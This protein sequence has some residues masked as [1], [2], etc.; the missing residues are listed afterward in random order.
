MKNLRKAVTAVMLTVSLVGSFGVAYADADISVRMDAVIS[1]GSDY[2]SFG[3]VKPMQIDNR[4]LIPARD[5]AEAAGM[6]VTWDQTTQTA[7]L[8]LTADAYSDKPIERYAAQLISQIEGFGLDLRPTSITAA[9][10]LYDST[11]VIRY[12]FTDSEGD[13]VPM[14][15]DYEMVSQAIL[16][17]DGTLM[18]P[19]RDSMEMFGLNVGWNQDELCAYVSI[20]ETVQVPEDIAIIANHGE[21]QYGASERDTTY[22]ETETNASSEE[23]PQLGAY[24]GRFKITHYCPC[25]ICNGS[26]GP[27]T[28]WAGE[29][30]P[31][32]TIAVN[33]NIIPKLSWVYVE[34]YGYR[35]AEDTGIGIEEYHIDMAV[36]THAMAMELGVVYKDVYFAE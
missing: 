25:S 16:I 9:L 28:A 17:D 34:D 21:G 32:Q 3:D 6:E 15:K 12:N 2:V 5:M 13:N 27:Y 11:A 10:K 19:V 24:I 36:P 1:D 29:L 18:V 31:G 35:R 23:K 33:Q 22:V 26:W 14:G 20:P 4:T 8:T 7:L 30:T